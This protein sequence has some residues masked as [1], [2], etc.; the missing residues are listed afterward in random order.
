MRKCIAVILILSGVAAGQL[1]RRDPVDAERVTLRKKMTRLAKARKS[2]GMAKPHTA[3]A[4]ANMID[5]PASKDLLPPVAEVK[6][7]AAE[8]VVQPRPD[9]HVVAAPAPQPAVAGPRNPAPAVAA[10]TAVAPAHEVIYSRTAEDV[11]GVNGKQE[12][13][14][15]EIARQYRARKRQQLSSS[16]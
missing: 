8:P 11:Q 10:T 3:L 13:S 5:Q 4:L 2:L 14:L 15:G 16:H 1:F 12:V 7:V 9:A 6:K